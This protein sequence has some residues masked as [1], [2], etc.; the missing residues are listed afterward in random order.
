MLTAV[1]VG[2]QK[3]ASPATPAKIGY[4]EQKGVLLFVADEVDTTDQDIRTQLMGDFK[5]SK[6]VGK[7]TRGVDL[8]LCYPDVDS[9]SKE[10]QKR[11]QSAATVFKLPVLSYNDLPPAG[12]SDSKKRGGTKKQWGGR[13]RANKKAKLAVV[14]S[15]AA[16]TPL[17]PDSD[18]VLPTQLYSTSSPAII[19]E[20]YTAAP[21][22]PQEGAMDVTDE[23]G[24]TR[25]PAPAPTPGAV[26]AAELLLVPAPTT[27]LLEFTG[28]STGPGPQEEIPVTTDKL[29]QL[30]SIVEDF[31]ETTLEP[32]PP[33]A[34]AGS[35]C[36]ETKATITAAT[37]L[38]SMG[39]TLTPVAEIVTQS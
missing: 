22:N 33:L 12:V 9:L 8:I 6:V 26:S 18:E 10:T 11:M 39:H 13:P 5:F 29:Q 3:G 19:E 14:E 36:S 17:P 4:L 2:S 30:P 24:S 1:P 15:P 23:A 16:Q 34:A 21:Y 27:K 28:T 20:P 31:A 35:S 7:N 37:P 25:A 38:L 32:V